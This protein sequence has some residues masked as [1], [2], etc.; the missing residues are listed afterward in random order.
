MLS[1]TIRHQEF[2]VLRPTVVALR[3]TNLLLSKWLTMGFL[4]I[5]FMRCSIANMTVNDDQRG[6]IV[7]RFKYPKSSLQHLQ[8]IDISHSRHI[9]AIGE[10]ACGN[11]LTKGQPCR[12][13][14]AD[15]VV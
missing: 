3:E 7:R 9:P 6:A 5:L 11:I 13:F 14:N 8:V 12:A 15:M 10:E 4:R 2:L 1:H